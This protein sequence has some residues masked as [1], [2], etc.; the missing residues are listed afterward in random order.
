MAGQRA[1][2]A[3]ARRIDLTEGK[4]LT[5]YTYSARYL[6][7]N[8][9][10]I[11]FNEESFR[12]DVAVQIIAHDSY[13]TYEFL[14]DQGFTIGRYVPIYTIVLEE[15][16]F[17]PLELNID[18]LDLHWGADQ[19]STVLLFYSATPDGEFDGEYVLQLDGD[20]LPD[21][22]SLADLSAFI[23]SFFRL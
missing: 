4:T 10:W 3:P 18:V 14:D 20:P 21:F 19:K 1:R 13:F 12:P 17:A 5:T 22:S 2:A 6:G 15:M 9:F 11:G 23:E 16:Q 8:H 7:W